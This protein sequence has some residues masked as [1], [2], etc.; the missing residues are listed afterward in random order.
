MTGVFP[1]PLKL[2]S[3]ELKSPFIL[4]PLESVSDCAF[5]RLC[6]EQ[7]AGFTWTEMVR[8]RGLVRGNQSTF[9]LLDTHD[10][11]T[12]TG[13]Q[14][15]VTG[16]QE[17][18]QALEAVEQA[19]AGARPHLRN[20]RAVDLNLGCPSPDVIRVGAGPAMLK[21]RAKLKAIFQALAAW[22]KATS[23]PVAAVGAK[24]RLGLHGG[25]QA[26]K[27]YLPVVDLANE[28]LDYLVVHARH[29]R[30]KSTDVPSWVAIAEAKQRSKI[31]VIGNGN[32]FCRAD[33]ERLF[34]KTRCDGALIARGAIRSPW[35]FRELLGEGPLE[36]T[37]AELDAAERRYALDAERWGSKTKYRTWHAEG[38][39]RIRARLEGKPEQGE[40]A[41]QNTNLG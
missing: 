40:A 14:L 26:H 25:E 24:I 9:D 36:P 4:A 29:A 11:E 18:A 10:P 30:E 34:R 19:A 20:L 31:P 27:V 8:A 39:Q 15:L 2:G 41:P 23:L 6:F 1:H 32:V 17:L 28:H 21:R 5:R 3:L 37:A 38:F 33:A 7:G 16:E 12:P 35:V 13:V 22:K